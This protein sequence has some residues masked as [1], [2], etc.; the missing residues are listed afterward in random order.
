MIDPSQVAGSHGPCTGTVVG[1]GKLDTP[2]AV[3]EASRR[4]AD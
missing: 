4:T 3:V 1:D 2:A